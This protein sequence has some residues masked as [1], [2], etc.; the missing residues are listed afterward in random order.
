LFYPRTIFLLFTFIFASL[1]F[2][3]L[4]SEL[5]NQPNS[6]FN[7]IFD[8]ELLFLGFNYILFG[9]YLDS[10]QKFPLSGPLYFFGAV[11]ILS[12]SYSLSGI[13]DLENFNSSIWKIVTALL[14]LASFLL[15][16]P[17]KSKSFLYWGG[18]FLVVYLTDLSYQFSHLFGR[19]GWPLLLILLGFFFMFT[20]YLVMHIHRK[21][22]RLKNP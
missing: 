6:I 5:T 18:I 10:D 1:F 9:R 21:I 16:V 4:V 17:L 12:A 2:I 11:F 22:T 8:Y 20:G 7:H 13:F 3:S 14:I 15:A 19:Y